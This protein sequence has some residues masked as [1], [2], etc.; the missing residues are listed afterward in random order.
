[1]GST[2][3]PPPTDFRV[4]RTIKIFQIPQKKIE[5]L[6]KT[7]CRYDREGSGNIAIDDFFEKIIKYPRSVLTDQMFQ[8][9]ESKTDASL[10]FGEFCEVICT[11]ACFEKIELMRYFFYILDPNRTGLVGKVE[12]KHFFMSMWNNDLSSNVK[13]GFAYLDS[14]DDGDGTFNFREVCT[15]QSK[16]PNMFFPLYRLQIKIIE[17]TFGEQWWEPHKAILNEQKE[18]IK[19]KELAELKLREKEEAEENAVVSDEM[20]QKRMGIFKYYLM[21]WLR[22]KE[23]AR[24]MKIAAIESE[25]DG[26]F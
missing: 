19:E 7:F 13:D 4:E 21:P 16:Y 2:L 9:I 25:L 17:N 12:L 24:I 5:I 20:I 10:N 23:K 14:I 11:F 26:K 22:E 15:L 6:W 18:K 3:A 1:M 8:L